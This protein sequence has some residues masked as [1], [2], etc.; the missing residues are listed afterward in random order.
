MD[1]P[2]LDLLNGWIAGEG[3]QFKS[4]KLTSVI[5]K[6]IDYATQPPP[7][8]EP[9]PPP[10]EPEPI[11]LMDMKQEIM[12]ELKVWLKG[13]ISDGAKVTAINDA[14]KRLAASNVPVPDD[15]VENILAEFM[16]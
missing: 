4:H 11:D 5:R 1:K 16:S 14:H 3:G 6:L 13:M 8:P 10:P 12:D 15:V 7:E 9:P 2:Y